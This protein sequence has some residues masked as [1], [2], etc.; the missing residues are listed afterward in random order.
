MTLVN[1]ELGVPATGTITYTRTDDNDPTTVKVGEQ[2]EL[3]P[4]TTEVKTYFVERTTNG[5]VR[6]WCN[7]PDV[8]GPIEYS[9]LVDI[10]PDTLDPT[11]EPEA[12]WNVA[13][14]DVV[15]TITANTDAIVDLADIVDTKAD[16]ADLAAGLAAKADT[17]A[18]TAEAAA[19]A[20]ADAL[21]APIA[22]P[23]FTGTVAGVTKAHVGLSA[24]DNTADVAKPVSVAQQAALDA[25]ADAATVTASLA[26][27]QPIDT[28]LTNIAALT[29]AD[30]QRLVW[31]S[32]LGTWTVTNPVGAGRIASARNVTGVVTSLAPG[33]S[34]GAGARQSIASTA[35]SVTNSGG[36]SVSIRFGAAFSQTVAGLGSVF[37]YLRE[38]TAGSAADRKLFVQPLTGA[39]TVG[40]QYVSCADEYD[41]GVVTTTRT[42][43]LQ[44]HLFSPTSSVP[45]VSIFNSSTAPSWI[46]ADA[47]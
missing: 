31:S 46:I 18:L 5:V 26:T 4:T 2:V 12:A 44:A 42:F 17:T 14:E 3:E 15:T 33:A 1:M 10:D 32:T 41:I 36:R 8:A 22:N 39:A 43:E 35:I 7:I 11:V 21:K 28:D 37:L 30:T 13:L 24:V 20:N 9:D 47:A 38:T 45:Q 6:R 29:P 27:K 19:R 40:N 34:G 23:T 25:K 16:A